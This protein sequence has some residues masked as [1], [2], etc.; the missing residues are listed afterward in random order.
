MGIRELEILEISLSGTRKDTDL[1]IYITVRE[2]DI[3]QAK[4]GVS[5]C[6]AY[7]WIWNT[8]QASARFKNTVLRIN[9]VAKTF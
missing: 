5:R 2:K 3:C 9:Q 6:K 4:V 7:P 8:H 1:R